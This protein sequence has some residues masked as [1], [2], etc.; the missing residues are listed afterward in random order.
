MSWVIKLSEWINRTSHHFLQWY[1]SLITITSANMWHFSMIHNT[2]RPATTGMF[3]AF[4]S[5]WRRLSKRLKYLFLQKK[6]SF[7]FF[8][9]S[10]VE[11][12]LIFSPENFI[13]GAEKTSLG[14]NTIWYA[15]YSKFANFSLGEKKSNFSEKLIYLF[16][17]TQIL[18][19]LRN[20]TISVA[21]HDNFA[22]NWLK[23]SCSE[24]VRLSRTLDIRNRQTSGINNI[25][26]DW[27]IFFP[28]Y[29]YGGKL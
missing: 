4:P 3:F 29:N 8:S 25:C 6:H 27:M 14:S 22:K 9:F 7:I 28:Y 16:K 26:V 24:S 1:Y 5:L 15:L 18:N 20:L 13:F 23:K 19:V 2:R 12:F 17:N 11:N 21:F 10:K